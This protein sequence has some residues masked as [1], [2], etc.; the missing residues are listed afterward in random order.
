MEI[1]L[2][3]INKLPDKELAVIKHR[4]GDGKEKRKTLEE[5]GKVLGLSRER[6]RQI[7]A[8]ALRKLRLF[9]V[10]E[11]TPSETTRQRLTP[12]GD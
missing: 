7:E 4:Y 10:N 2:I 3:H 9:E 1:N 12:I 8:K 5:V 6:V 11:V